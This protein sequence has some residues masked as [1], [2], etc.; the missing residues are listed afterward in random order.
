MNRTTSLYGTHART[1]SYFLL[2][3]GLLATPAAIA[4]STPL[5]HNAVSLDPAAIAAASDTPASLGGD[6]VITIAWLRADVPVTVDGL[7][8]PP[9]AGLGSWAAFMPTQDGAMVMGDTVVFQDEVDAAMDAAFAHGLEVT[10]LHNHFF[11]SDPPVFFMH[12]NGQGDPMALAQ[13]VKAVWA[14][15]RSV[16]TQRIVPARHFPGG[17][18]VPGHLNAMAISSA[19]GLTV[20][21]NHGVL[22]AS[23]GHTSSMGGMTIGGTSGLT[24]WIA[25]VGSDRLSVADGDFIMYGRDVQVVLHAL[26]HAGFHIVALHNHMIGEKPV[27]YFTHFW[28]KGSALDLARSFKSVLE[29]QAVSES[30]NNLKEN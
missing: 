12:I 22:K 26:R 1:L 23:F 11:Y 25:L 9:P 29:A 18:P 3:F 14:A 4:D 28:G 30:K 6:G 13:G 16:R 17:V 10:A 5:S 20:T 21:D 2:V 15:I 7:K 24:T 27:V 8:L 19:L